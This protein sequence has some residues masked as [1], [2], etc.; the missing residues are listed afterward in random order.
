MYINAMNKTTVIKAYTER[1]VAGGNDL[2][3]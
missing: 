3:W 2:R 1:I